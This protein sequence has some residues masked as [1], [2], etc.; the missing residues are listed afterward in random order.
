MK[1]H[2]VLWRFSSFLPKFL[3]DSYSGQEC[4]IIRAICCVRKLG[5]PRVPKLPAAVPEPH[6]RSGWDAS[7]W[8]LSWG[9]S[10]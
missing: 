6:T 4:V 2:P 3:L 5:H 1:G 9:P 10:G 8:V 7:C